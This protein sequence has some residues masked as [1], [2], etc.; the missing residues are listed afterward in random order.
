MYVYLTLLY[1][2][3][4]QDEILDMVI[5]RY[6]DMAVTTAVRNNI[7]LYRSIVL[8]KYLHQS[9]INDMTEDNLFG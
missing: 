4:Y 9:E 2:C 8:V 7:Y 3:L 1:G 5:W 6:G